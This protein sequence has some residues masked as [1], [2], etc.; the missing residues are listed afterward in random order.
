[1]ANNQKLS[2]EALM[3]QLAFTAYTTQPHMVKPYAGLDEDDQLALVN[4]V[5]FDGAYAVNKLTGELGWTRATSHG[6]TWNPD[7]IQELKRKG[8][9]AY[10]YVLVK[11]SNQ[12]VAAQRARHR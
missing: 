6:W 1:M 7:W 3:F 8:H 10:F 9:L 4:G 2:T 5:G 11:T 12:N